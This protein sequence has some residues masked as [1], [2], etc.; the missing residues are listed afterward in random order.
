MV[1]TEDPGSR[2][3]A[4]LAVD[5]AGA[6]GAALMDE[7]PAF[8]RALEDVAGRIDVTRSAGDRRA[9]LRDTIGELI[10]EWREQ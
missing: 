4:A 10:Q 8:R 1:L 2:V 9:V 5:T 6:G 3:G 7:D